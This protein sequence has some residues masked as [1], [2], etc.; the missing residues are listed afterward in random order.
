MVE[1]DEW[2]LNHG[3]HTRSSSRSVDSGSPVA[4]CPEFDCVWYES[5]QI[6]VPVPFWSPNLAQS[7][8]SQQEQSKNRG[9]HRS[10]SKDRAC[11]L[12]P[13][14]RGLPWLS[15]PYW[16]RRANNPT[17]ILPLTWLL[18]L[19]SRNPHFCSGLDFAYDHFKGQIQNSALPRTCFYSLQRNPMIHLE[20]CFPKDTIESWNFPA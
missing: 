16:K 15:Q 12:F 19:V 4:Q 2:E 13:T 10:L 7:H 3:V 18:E 11:H 20:A 5:P 6:N 17:C 8:T 14:P 1:T 9:A